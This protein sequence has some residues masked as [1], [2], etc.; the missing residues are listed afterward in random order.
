VLLVL[1]TLEEVATFNSESQ[2]LGWMSC[3][4]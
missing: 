1:T 3:Y 2:V 4:V